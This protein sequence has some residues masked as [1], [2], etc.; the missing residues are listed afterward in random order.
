MRSTSSR[1]FLIL[2][3]SARSFR[4]GEVWPALFAGLRRR[5]VDFDV[6]LTTA[7]G[8]PA[9]LVHGAVAQGARTIVAV[10]GD[11]TI[12]DALNGLFPL[13][14]PFSAP[15]ASTAT[16]G[17]LYTG[18]SPDFC[19][20]HRIPL[21]LEAALDLLCSGRHRRV[22]VCR[23][24]CR[25]G[26]AGPAVTRVF[27]CCANFGLGAAVARLAN[28]GLRRRFGDGLGTLLALMRSVLKTTACQAPLAPSASPVTPHQ[29][30]PAALPT[31]RV[32]LDGRDLVFPRLGNLFVGKSPLVASGIRLAVDLAPDDGQ[33][34]VLPVAGVSR[35][36][37]FALLPRAYTGGL[38]RRF[39]PLYGRRLEIMP[40][41]EAPEV[42]YDGD[43]RGFLPAAIEVLPRALDLIAPSP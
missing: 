33:M 16:F 13:V 40:C 41:P 5:Q 6:A 42:E 10:G 27:G 19:R 18:T 9:E 14:P 4:A 32:R 39:P 26:P 25:A 29:R 11:G 3:P 38:A 23:I 31:L 2:N 24:T 35:A 36:R 12:N 28:S 1:M 21:D 43:P 22:D 37:L 30:P 15:V 20:H 7:D 17:V 34:Y 8:D